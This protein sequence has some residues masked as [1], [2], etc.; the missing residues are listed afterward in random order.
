MLD[1]LLCTVHL[2]FFCIFS[3]F[4]G[5][6]PTTVMQV[7]LIPRMLPRLRYLGGNAE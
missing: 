6:D 2:I 5:Q 4:Y 3:V 7:F 1:S